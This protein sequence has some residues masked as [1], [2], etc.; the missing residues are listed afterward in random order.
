MND[1]T[2]L[3]YAIAGGGVSG[4]YCGYRL[5]EAATASG[6]SSPSVAIFEG[7]GELG[8]R[9]CSVTPPLIP[10]ARV[11]LGGMRY[12]AKAQ[13]LITD[14]VSHL[15]LATEPLA[16]DQPQNIAYLRGTLLRQFE[17]TDASKVPYQLGPDD[18]SPEALSNLTATAAMRVL[19]ETIADLFGIT[20]THWKQLTELSEAQWR[21]IAEEGT[22]KGTLLSELPL[23]YLMLE[24]ISHEAWNLAQD[25]SGYDSILHTW[26]G[27]DGF[28]W[29]V[30]DYGPTVEYLHVKD[31]YER[32]P[33]EMADRFQKAGGDIHLNTR[34][35]R[36]TRDDDG[37][38]TLTLAVDGGTRTVRAK[39]LILAMPR[40]SLELIDPVGPV[41]DPSHQDVRDLV[42]SVVPIPLFK[43]AICYERAWWEDLPPV[44]AGQGPVRIEK[45]KS[46]TDL[47][48]R[49]CYYWKVDPSNGHAVILIYDDGVAL[50]YWAGLRD[51]H[52]DPFPHDPDAFD[53]EFD[54][55]NW[56]EYPAPRRMV[57]EVHRQLVELHGHPPDVPAPYT[58]AY[59]DWGEDPFGGGANFWPVG[60]RSYEVA[61]KMLQPRPPHPV[62][63]CGDCY[64]HG[65]GW[66]EGALATAEGVLQRHLG[67]QAPSWSSGASGAGTDAGRTPALP[68]DHINVVTHDLEGTAAFFCDNFGFVAGEGRRMSGAWVDELT[69]YADAEVEFVPLAVGG[70]PAA[71][72]I[73]LLHY[74][75][76]PTPPAPPSN[77][78]LDEPGYRH[79]G[80]EVDDVDAY[81]ERMKNDWRFFSAPVTAES[82]HAKTVYLLGPES[83]IVQLTQ[84][85]GG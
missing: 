37:L 27:A 60:V 28:S 63:V 16:A 19:R 34:L 41:L 72:K 4:I 26:S 74:L 29:N 54:L 61:E 55:P 84:A 85:L 17:L 35:Q 53:G 15:Q 52:G 43:L 49:Q 70:R 14:L 47:P 44:D 36:F 39:N 5:L 12:I 83:I 76:P 51:R 68:I 66:V 62:Y 7:R 75:N 57:E 58:A 38:L 20:I 31:G 24:V 8:G 25:A 22:W 67:L 13:P 48:V 46:V 32:V 2:V 1:T 40:R 11:E 6:G 71:T 3:D 50:D 82:L 64:S 42:E 23:R 59:R 21:R 56:G 9:L 10:D 80:F 65:Q 33:L 81:Y 30:G 79:I 78:R 69:G 77:S 18:R 73:A 45:G